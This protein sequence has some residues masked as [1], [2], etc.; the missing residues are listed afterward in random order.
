[1]ENKNQK[2]ISSL[3]RIVIIIVMTVIVGLAAYFYYDIFI[4]GSGPLNPNAETSNEF[5][6][7]SSPAINQKIGN[8]VQVSGKSK[9]FEGNTRIR[10]KDENKNVLANTFT[11]AKGEMGELSPFSKDVTYQEPTTEKGFI[12][13][14]EDS[15]KDGSGINKITIPV[16]FEN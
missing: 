13:I 3:L 14:F 12:E 1:M 4:V 8:P 9:F 7:V 15:A 6:I 16:I 2:G 10:I 11:T 5:L